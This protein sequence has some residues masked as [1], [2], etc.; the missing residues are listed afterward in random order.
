MLALM[1]RLAPISVLVRPWAASRAIAG[2]PGGQVEVAFRLGPDPLAGRLEFG[3]GALGERGRASPLQHLHGDPEMFAG[4]PA[5]LAPAEPLAVEQVGPSAFDLDPAPR[6]GCRS[7]TGSELSASA[8]AVISARDRSATP[9]A[10]SDPLASAIAVSVSTTGHRVIG[11]AA[12]HRGFHEVRVLQR[13][14]LQERV[15]DQRLQPVI[16][17]AV[18]ALGQVALGERGDRRGVH[19]TETQLPHRL[20]DPLHLGPGRPDRGEVRRVDHVLG[21]VADRPAEV[22]YLL[23]VFPGPPGRPAA[24]LGQRQDPQDRVEQLQRPR[25]PGG[26]GGSLQTVGAGR[27]DP[28]MPWSGPR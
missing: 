26:L 8:S 1:N 16:G 24:E 20:G 9:R 17:I 5:S 25:L 19:T 15:V 28:T 21:L 10:Q 4:V 27:G 18:V 14:D 13:G 23:D 2:L 22:S 11:V 6:P 7:R 12:S 3:A